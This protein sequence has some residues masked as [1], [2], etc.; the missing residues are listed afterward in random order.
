[1][2]AFLFRTALY[3]AIEEGNMN[4]V[5]LILEHNPDVNAKGPNDK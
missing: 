1:M 3:V 4:M 5:Y 2:L